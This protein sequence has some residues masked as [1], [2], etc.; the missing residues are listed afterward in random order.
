M[1]QDL[2]ERESRA[3]DA[4]SC[5]HSISAPGRPCLLRE[6]GGPGRGE[7]RL[8]VGVDMARSGDA[9]ETARDLW[10]RARGDRRG[11]RGDI[12]VAERLCT[13]L[14]FGLGRWVGSD[15]YRALLDRA[16]GQTRAAHPVLDGLSCHGSGELAARGSMKG[17]DAGEIADGMIAMVTALIELLGRI[18]GEEMS[19]RLVDQIGAPG[20]QGGENIKGKAARD[21]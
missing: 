19:I 1:P 2:F 11:S 14:R 9:A 5:S 18:I 21:G 8:A 7:G 17:P 13:H 4:S 12:E 10:A 15:G 6:R 3:Y 20:I 16:I